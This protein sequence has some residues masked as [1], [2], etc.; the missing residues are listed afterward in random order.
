M[1][2]AVKA[3]N[4]WRTSDLAN[5]N[6]LR[7]KKPVAIPD[8]IASTTAVGN[9]KIQLYPNPVTTN[10]FNIQFTDADAGNYTIQ[11]T[12]ARGQLA[13]QKQISIGGKGN[14]TSISLTRSAAKG[15]YIVKVTDNNSKIVYS[16]KIV[17]Q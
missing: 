1:A 16:N 3:D 10:Q 8:L 6:I 9:D 15:I 5:S 13:A 12:D 7:T 4:P 14:V 17:V 11:V 2:K